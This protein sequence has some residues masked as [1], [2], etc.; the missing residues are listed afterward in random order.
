MTEMQSTSTETI[1][2]EGREFRVGDRIERYVGDTA[3]ITAL[4]GPTGSDK[5]ITVSD[6]Y[7][8][9]TREGLVINRRSLRFY[10]HV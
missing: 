8:G 5:S 6:V 4:A 3:T 7:R 2:V 1:T 9:E 10:R